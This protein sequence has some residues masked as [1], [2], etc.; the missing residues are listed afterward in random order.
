[1]FGWSDLIGVWRLLVTWLGWLGL[2]YMSTDN[3][4]ET[5]ALISFLLGTVFSVGVLSGGPIGYYTAILAM[6]HFL[7]YWV[8]AKYRKTQVSVGSFLLDHSREY[9][10]GVVV[11]VLEYYIG[12]HYSLKP[13]SNLFI[14]IGNYAIN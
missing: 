7:E 1:L 14:L 2:D 12:V 13:N 8:A 6:F 10:A 11:A 3:S 5:V 4:A 9:W